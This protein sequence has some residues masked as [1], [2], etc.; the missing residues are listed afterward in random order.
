MQGCGEVGVAHA[1]VA[2]EDAG[3]DLWRRADNQSMRSI[4]SEG[5][6]MT[7]AAVKA[8]CD[9]TLIDSKSVP[10]SK[11]QQGSSRKCANDV[12]ACETGIQGCRH[13]KG[14]TIKRDVLLQLSVLGIITQL[15]SF[16]QQSTFNTFIFH[17]SLSSPQFD[18]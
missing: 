9:G 11:E 15:I 5:I 12:E 7:S 2:R 3:T 13:R 18:I 4:Q 17:L 14:T 8:W 1:D 16:L 10:R 6:H